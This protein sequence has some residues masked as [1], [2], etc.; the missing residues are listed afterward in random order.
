ML[1]IVRA[2][3]GE[4]EPVGAVDGAGD[5][6][7]AVQGRQRLLVDRR[8][9]ARQGVMVHGDRG[10]AGTR[11]GCGRARTPSAVELERLNIEEVNP[12]LRGGRVENHLGKTTPSSP[13]RDSNLDLPVLS[14]LAQHDW[15]VSQLRHGGG[16]S[17]K[18]IVIQQTKE[19]QDYQ[20]DRNER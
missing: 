11:G 12:H 7:R 8:V 3:V 17:L 18:T 14:G 10:P 6:V 19:E 1:E 15:R 4:A 2:A 13:D 20:D 16:S 9:W 5:P